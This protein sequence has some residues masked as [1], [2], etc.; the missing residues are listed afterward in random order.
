LIP[1]HR[2][3][4][5][6]GIFQVV[7]SMISFWL[8]QTALLLFLPSWCFF[9]VYLISPSLTPAAL[10]FLLIVSDHTFAAIHT[11]ISPS[12]SLQFP[13][14]IFLDVETHLKIWN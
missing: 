6:M 10:L 9:G 7:N 11:C 2:L 8:L 13:L 12:T 5:I 3:M 1:M 14:F 4:C